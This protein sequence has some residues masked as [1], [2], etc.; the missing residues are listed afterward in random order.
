M[1]SSILNILG[2]LFDIIGAIGL[3]ITIEDYYSNISI[4]DLKL[5]GKHFGNEGEKSGRALAQDIINKKEPP[6]GKLKKMYFMFIVLGFLFQLSSTIVSSI[7]VTAKK[8][9]YPACKNRCNNN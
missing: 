3:Y 7:N 1:T 2:L 9:N 6:R 8:T 4:N 5:M